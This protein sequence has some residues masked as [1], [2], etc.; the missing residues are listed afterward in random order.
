MQK[1]LYT[2]D[3]KDKIRI[4]KIEVVKVPEGANIHIQHGIL[5]GAIVSK[6]KT[7]IEGKNIGRSNE[8]TPL[9]QA[10]LESIS[11]WQNQKDTGYFETIEEARGT[12]VYLPMLAHIF[13]KRKHNITYPAYVQPKLDGVRCLAKKVS[14][15]EIHFMSRGG[16]EYDV[17]QKHSMKDVLLSAMKVGDVYDGEIYKHGWSLQKITSAV[18]KFKETTSELEYWIFDMATGGTFEDRFVAI[19]KNPNLMFLETHAVTSEEDVYAYHDEFVKQGYE[20]VIIRNADGS[21]AFGSRS[22]D[23][24]KHKQFIDDEFEIVGWEVE[25]HSINN[26]HY[27][28]IVYVCVTKEGSTFK[29]R[30][31]GSLKTRGELLKMADELVGKH[32]TVRYQTLTDDTE[33]KGRKVPQFPVGICIRDYE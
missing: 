6:S 7:I 29:C 22:S 33:G 18:K 24:Q 32:L 15:S 19:K 5:N 14:E 20:G 28:C 27:K 31:R 9:Q 16:N 3:S 4:W 13:S 10:E 23:L 17:L 25:E 30:P 12:M 1:I 26:E 21:Y 11:A 2:K 8:T